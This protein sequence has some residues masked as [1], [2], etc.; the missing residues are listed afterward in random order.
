[1]IRRALPEDAALLTTLRQ[2]M[3]Q[4]MHPTL[5]YDDEFSAQHC[6][7]WQTMLAANGAAAW[8]A[9]QANGT[10]GMLAMLLQHHP[11]LPLNQRRRGYITG[12]YVHPDHRRRGL[13]KQLLNA[14]ITYG[15]TSGLQRLELRTSEQGR[16]LYTAL[17]FEPREIL[18][19]DLQ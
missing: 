14:A 19:L 10:V 18:M 6:H 15:R 5:P 1:M 17:G 7:Y 11:P 4:E 9:E 3:W 8:L 16:P 13:G 12:V 2:M